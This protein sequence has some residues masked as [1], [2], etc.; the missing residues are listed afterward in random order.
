[1]ILL[2]F[3]AAYENYQNRQNSVDEEFALRMIE[4]TLEYAQQTCG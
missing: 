4:T 3:L 2:A 1:M